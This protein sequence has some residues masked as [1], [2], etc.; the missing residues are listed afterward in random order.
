M[1]TSEGWRFREVGHN[2]PSPQDAS[3]RMHVAPWHTV[4]GSASQDQAFGAHSWT[5]TGL[6]P[7][8]GLAN[9]LFPEAEFQEK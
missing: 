2:S 4:W 3:M 9:A 6:Q 7:C 1:T 8:L 5:R